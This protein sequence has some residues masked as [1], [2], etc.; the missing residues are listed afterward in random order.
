MEQVRLA[1]PCY[2]LLRLAAA[3]SRRR[4]WEVGNP[5]MFATRSFVLNVSH[6][7]VVVFD[8]SLERPFNSWTERHVAQ[9]FAWRPGSVAFGTVEE[10]GPHRVSVIVAPVHVVVSS[11]AVRVI[12][13]P[14]KVPPHGEV[15]IA[16]VADTVPLQLP[17]Q[18]DSLRFEYLVGSSAAEIALTFMRTGSPTFKIM[19]SDAEPFTGELL[20]N[21]SPA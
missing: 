11:R 12:E 2:I 8:R 1:Y 20:L 15:E 5:Y 6:S 13:V 10:S 7:Q 17:S 18:L 16:S 19:H 4:R 9:G 14:F 3:S 21:A